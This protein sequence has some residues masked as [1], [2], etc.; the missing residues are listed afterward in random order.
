LT[1]GYFDPFVLSV[2]PTLLPSAD[3]AKITLHGFGF[4]QPDDPA[5]LKIKYTSPKGDIQYVGG[6]P[7][8]VQGTYVD[9]FT[10]EAST[11]SLD[12]LRYPDGSEVKI[13]DTIWPEVS[14]THEDD[15]TEN[16]LPIYHYLEVG[17]EDPDDVNSP[18]NIELPLTIGTDFYWSI[19][20]FPEFVEESNFTCTWQCSHTEMVTKG[21]IETLPLGSQYDSSTKGAYVA[22]ITP[23]FDTHCMGSL[24]ISVNGQDKGKKMPYEF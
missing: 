13:G 12:R 21:R 1:Y 11:A 22:C 7:Y 2:T 15:F 16:Q 8:V 9:K 17:A 24:Q 19:N 20:S 23:N 6:A 14:T 4:I 18:Q 3:P 5:D 10:I